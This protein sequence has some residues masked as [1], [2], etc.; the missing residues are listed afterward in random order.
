[1]QANHYHS[2][3]RVFRSRSSLR[4]PLRVRCNAQ[5]TDSTNRP[6]R[7]KDAGE[8]LMIYCLWGTPAFQAEG[9]ACCPVH[10]LLIQVS[11]VVIRILSASSAEQQ[12]ASPARIVW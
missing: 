8:Q 2:T 10:M 4:A 1:M 6:V 5:E 9:S 7:K 12:D 3:G 11:Q